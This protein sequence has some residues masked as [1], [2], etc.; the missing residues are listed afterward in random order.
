MNKN[1]D[2]QEIKRYQS[3]ERQIKMYIRDLLT[4]I[5][6]VI[7]DAVKKGKKMTTKTIQ[8]NYESRKM[9]EVA[10]RRKVWCGLISNL[11]NRGFKV[12]IDAREKVPKI[13]ISWESDEEKQKNDK[14]IE[15]FKAHVKF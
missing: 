2:V 6:P 7:D 5:N 8:K 10:L 11:E 1:W 12:S 9:T 4:V 3:D 13:E 15:Y 14:E